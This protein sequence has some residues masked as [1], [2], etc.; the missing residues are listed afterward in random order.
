[1]LWM[2]KMRKGRDRA[3]SR[4]VLNQVVERALPRWREQNL[5]GAE[6]WAEGQPV[7]RP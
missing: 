6:A 2:E 4:A 3:G 1:M 5:R 7:Q